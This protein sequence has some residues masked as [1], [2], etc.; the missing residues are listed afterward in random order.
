MSKANASKGIYMI[1]YTYILTC[2]DKSFYVGH[3]SDLEERVKTH[4]L[5]KGARFTALRRPVTLSYSETHESQEDAIK[6]E[7]QIKKWS[8]AKKQALICGDKQKLKEL[9]KKSS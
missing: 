8:R 3:T 1:W 6:R 7:K 2:S 4:N 9:S 5:G